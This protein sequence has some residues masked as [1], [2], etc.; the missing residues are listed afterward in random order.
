LS[1]RLVNVGAVTVS[2]ADCVAVPSAAVILAIRF[3]ATAVV[4]TVKVPVV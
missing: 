3:A 2:A 4:L 1:V